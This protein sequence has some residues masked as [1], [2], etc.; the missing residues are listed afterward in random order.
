MIATGAMYVRDPHRMAPDS[1]PVDTYP[2][3]VT[4]E[5]TDL[6]EDAMR[7]FVYT[8]RKGVYVMHLYTC[9]RS[10]VQKYANQLFS[11]VQVQVPL[12]WRERRTGYEAGKWIFTMSVGR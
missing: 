9:N 11:D 6:E 7:T 4:C 12:V 1:R 8:L 3:C 10:L 2:E 5:I